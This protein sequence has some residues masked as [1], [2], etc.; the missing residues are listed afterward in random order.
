[1]ATYYVTT[2]A[3]G[4]SDSHT[5]TQAQTSSTGWL[6]LAYACSQVTSSGNIIHVNAGTFIET[7]QSGLHAGVSI[8]GAGIT[9]IIKSHYTSWTIL[10]YSGSL[11]NGNQHIWNIKMDGDAL[12]GYAPI[13]VLYRSNVEISGCTF[14]DFSTYGVSFESDGNY[15]PTYVTGNSFHHNTVTNC[16][17]FIVNNTTYGDGH[18]LLMISGQQTMRIYN[19][20]LDQ[21]QRATG[22]N[23][24]CIKAIYGCNKDIKIYNN[25]ITKAPF[26]D[27][28]WD[29]ALELW[30]CMGGIEIYN[31][32]ISAGIDFGGQGLLKGSYA[33]GAWVHDNIIGPATK[34]STTWTRYTKCIYFE[35]GVQTVIIERNHF[36]NVDIGV[37]FN[38]QNTSDSLL[39]EVTNVDI[40]YN[41]FENMYQY[42]ISCDPQTLPTYVVTYFHCY[43]NTIIGNAV[44]TY[45]GIK[46]PAF[47]AGP[48]GVIVENNIIQGFNSYPVYAAY[49][50]TS[51][52]VENNDF[53]LNGYTVPN[54]LIT[55]TISNNLTSNP[56]LISSGDFHLQSGSP[57]IGHGLTITGLSTD[58]AGDAVNSPPEMGVYKYGTSV[59]VTSITVTGAGSA[60]TIATDNG[61]LQMSASVSPGG[62]T[63]STISWSLIAGTGNGTI[64]GSGLLTA[65]VNGTVTVRATSTDGSGVYGALVITISNQ[66]I[67]DLNSGLMSYW[68]LDEISGNAIDS[69]GFR[70]LTVSNVTQNQT[71]KLGKSYYF[72]GGGFLGNVD[73][74]Y[75]LTSAISIVCWL[76]TS[77][78]GSYMDLISDYYPL[79][80]GYGYDLII[81][82]TGHLYWTVY[83]TTQSPSAIGVNTSTSITTGSWVHAVA[84]FDGT[85]ACLYINGTLISTSSAWNHPIVYNSL[86]RF[87]IGNRTDTLPFTG[88]I[89]EVGIYNRAITQTEVNLLYNAGVGLSYPFSTSRG[90]VAV[91]SVDVT[92]QGDAS[93]INTLNGTLQMFATVSPSDA[94]VQ[95]VVWSVVGGTGTA[96][97]DSNGLL[98]AVT[99]GTVTVIATANG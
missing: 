35:E 73:S 6:T 36:K 54:S 68:K 86:A 39:S 44:A 13:E 74:I 57:V 51:V 71:G 32:T 70:D 11:T 7:V 17:A 48:T 10:L 61:T 56:L 67:I 85:Y 31:N 84:T 26:D 37:W 92:S 55:G 58:Y 59:P 9:S 4:G 3:N 80:N 95:T 79:D 72:G 8:E 94:T 1:M 75:E 82:N 60:T 98:T 16:S 42:G 30:T 40:R 23:G 28:T 97:I 50:M 22:Y 19:N 24:Y 63:N 14:V 43:N 83:N 45:Y 81:S 66:D 12:T 25:I 27:T 88:N 64:S 65:T 87:M 20:T 69:V 52:L 15:P 21:T 2:A 49:T 33:Y 76:N 29:F 46:L 34:A 89:D 38:T 18:G 41:I 91:T 93:E 5:S 99:D 53:Y 78:S 62:A 90:L 47:G 96:S 77:A